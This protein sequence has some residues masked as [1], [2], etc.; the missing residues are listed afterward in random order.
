MALSRT[1]L[2]AAATRGRD[3]RLNR[4]ILVLSAV[5]VLGTIMT[6]LDLTIVNVA[7]PTLGS[8]L[9]ASTPWG[10]SWPGRC[11]RARRGR[12]ARWSPSASCKGSAPG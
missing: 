3:D 7:I 6:V 4:E 10:C 11:S 1:E 9:H 8:D 12:S 2:A 5:V